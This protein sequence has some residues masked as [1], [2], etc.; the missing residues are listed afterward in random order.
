LRKTTFVDELNGHLQ[1]L[2]RVFRRRLD[3]AA[4][5]PGRDLVDLSVI[6]TTVSEALAGLERASREL[7]VAEG[8]RG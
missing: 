4:G 8:T 5:E 2:R 3:D 6:E 7:E 1:E